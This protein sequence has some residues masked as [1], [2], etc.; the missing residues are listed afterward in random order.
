MKVRCSQSLVLPCCPD[1]H[2]LALLGLVYR[3]G[4]FTD[5][6]KDQ[7]H[8]AITQYAA[9]CVIHINVSIHEVLTLVKRSDQ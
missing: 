6:E 9:V 7:V 4:K 8:T 5:T 3:K 1:V 2:D